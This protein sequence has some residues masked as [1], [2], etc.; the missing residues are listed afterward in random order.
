MSSLISRVA[1]L[2]ALKQKSLIKLIAVLSVVTFVGNIVPEWYSQ[3]PSMASEES[4]VTA[5]SPPSHPGTMF[6]MVDRLM[7]PTFDAGDHTGGQCA[8]NLATDAIPSQSAAG[9][10]T[11]YDA[12]YQAQTVSGSNALTI[13]F[14]NYFS[15]LATN[16]EYNVNYTLPNIYRESGGQLIIDGRMGSTGKIILQDSSSNHNS[17]NHFFKISDPSPKTGSLEPQFVTIRNIAFTS[18]L[19]LTSAAITTDNI[20]TTGFKEGVNFN[21]LHIQNNYFGTFDGV[22]L[23]PTKAIIQGVRVYYNHNTAPATQISDNNFY[24]VIGSSIE[25]GGNAE[26]KPANCP[27]YPDNQSEVDG[28]LLIESNVIGLNVDK[29]ITDESYFGQGG[30]SGTAISICQLSGVTITDNDIAN[31]LGIAM[32]TAIGI[33]QAE[34][35]IDNNR[36]G[37]VLDGTTYRSDDEW[38][39][40]GYGILIG[41]N[42]EDRQ[43]P[44]VITN[45]TINNIKAP[46]VPGVITANCPTP[47]FHSLTARGGSCG[48]SGIHLV[49]TSFN[50]IYQNIIGSALQ[51]N[52]GYGIE[53][54]GFHFGDAITAYYPSTYNKIFNNTIGYNAADG[55]YVDS[56]YNLATPRGYEDLECE[57]DF[58]TSDGETNNC[59]NTIVQ[60][61]LIRNGAYN[62]NDFCVSESAC[63][64]SP[65]GGIGI[66]LKTTTDDLE[67]KYGYIEDFYTGSG[68]YNDS[69]ITVNDDLDT[70]IGGNGAINTPV[71]YGTGS[72]M[73]GTASTARVIYGNLSDSTPGAYWVEV[74]AVNCP[75]ELGSTSPTITEDNA[76]T[77][78]D[79]DSISL[80]HQ[81]NNIT[82]GQGA[83][84]LCGAFV[85]KVG[86][87][88]GEWNCSPSAQF[89]INFNGA[90]LITATA[91]R[92]ADEGG[93]LPKET[94]TGLPAF[95]RTTQFT[96]GY[97]NYIF[98]TAPAECTNSTPDTFV[99]TTLS[100]AE[101]FV[102]I[103]SMNNS[104]EFS[105][106]V[107]VAPE[108]VDIVKMVRACSGSTGASCESNVFAPEITSSREQYVEYR[109]TVTNNTDSAVTPTI[110]DE[111]HPG[112]VT[113]LTGSC[114]TYNGLTSL[115]ADRPSTG[116]TPVT[117]TGN[118]DATFTPTIAA[119][120]SVAFFGM[121]RINADANGDSK[122]NIGR[123]ILPS[124][125][126][127]TSDDPE[128]YCT[129][130]ARVRITAPVTA[131][132]LKTIENP[133]ANG[134]TQTETITSSSSSQTI[135][136]RIKLD[137]SGLTK[138]NTNGLTIFDSFPRTI[139]DSIQM[140]YSQTSCTYTVLVNGVTRLGPNACLNREQ[141]NTTDDGIIIWNSNTGLPPASIINETTGDIE[142]VY[143]EFDTV[144]VIITYT[145]TVPANAITAS[146][147]VDVVNKATFSGSDVFPGRTGETTLTITPPQVSPTIQKSV[148][149]CTSNTVASCASATFNDTGVT[150]APGN[151]VEY[152]LAIT[153]S[154]N[155]TFAINDAAPTGITF[156]SD[157]GSCSL[158]ANLT[159]AVA[160]T[161]ARPSSTATPCTIT[162]A[163]GATPQT[164]AM[165]GQTLTANRFTYVYILATVSPSATTAITNT[166]TIIGSG[167][168]TENVCSNTA[169][170]TPSAVPGEVA[171]DKQASA[172][173]IN[174]GQTV[175]YTVTIDKP[176]TYAVNG[177]TL[178]DSFPTNS[179]GIT[180][181]CQSVTV[182]PT[183]SQT[184]SCPTGGL[185][186]SSGNIFGGI[187]IAQAVTRITVVYTATAPSSI[188]TSQ[189]LV[190]NVALTG[191]RSTD[192]GAISRTDSVPVLITTGTI[193]INKTAD[194]NVT[195]TN[196]ATEKIYKPGDTVN[197]T[198]SL[199]NTSGATVAGVSIRD[200]FHSLLGSIAVDTTGITNTITLGGLNLTGISVPTGTTPTTIT[201]HGTIADRSD[202]DLDIFDLDENSNPARDDDFYA[203][204][205]DS[206]VIDDSIRSTNNSHR[207]ADDILGAPDNKFVSLNK[208]DITIDL[209]SKVIVNG[210][211]DDFALK[212][213]NQNTDDTDQGT[214]EFTVEVSQ[215]NR[216]YKEIDPRDEDRASYDLSKARMSWVRYIRITDESSAT[217]AQAPGVDIDAICLL[218]IGV[219]LPNTATLTAG[220]QTAFDTEEI[221]VDI[222]KVFDKKPSIDNC[223][224]PELT[225][226]PVPPLAA[227]PTV[228]PPVQPTPPAPP[229][230]LPKTGPAPL[231]L[232]SIVS[233][234]A[235]IFTRKRQ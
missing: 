128:N 92:V 168:T 40:F 74:F 113:W 164:L 165:S 159:T 197:Y 191:T 158:Y 18:L 42:Y 183:G 109:I 178:H 148:R 186:G 232:L 33:S 58:G 68:T 131:T 34:A 72:D 138:A 29:E 213:I 162:P 106:N 43:E 225:V 123:L 202:F 203:S 9:T 8:V 23:D 95:T 142:D 120:T 19:K 114:A 17:L 214:E 233:S 37:N 107:Y 172:S 49:A 132:I 189:T 65:T 103:Y 184:I 181:A 104:S 163:S 136:Y 76:F 230:V 222:T 111:L 192:G 91:T 161:G 73:S 81:D 152:R 80:N 200:V 28:S 46:F 231:A 14:S 86:G 129:S 22:T 133:H 78:C 127:T 167:C 147:A 180:Y 71:L 44:T 206:E 151:T 2:F 234:F 64:E 169:L 54:V 35:T 224:E 219:Q 121:V 99:P 60:N 130:I 63:T 62:E 140:T 226:A 190:N 195:G 205:D 144:T 141:I 56:I 218:N 198:L 146:P 227:P 182:L 160:A 116:A 52:T 13:I 170:V 199:L 90:G 210:S 3:L 185:P 235:W 15:T 59:G 16:Y 61:N 145:G 51:I 154:A 50:F 201:Y 149:T 221:T 212:L 24:N 110:R 220:S 30:W 166:A 21:Q 36:I 187:T 179:V 12:I 194:N 32:D 41:G 211:G 4:E 105:Q 67:Q 193:S 139:R 97:L 150:T 207:R 26:A 27:Q 171:L 229:P 31:S 83:R 124:V 11:L 55:I 118:T 70:D 215:D 85:L 122:D 216:T 82:H 115:P 174:P 38:Q 112:Q 100:D 137:L 84:F 7:Q 208:G 209:G 126:C 223:T 204:E 135:D 88:A 134:T 87:D 47:S 57:T 196:H 6:I 89:G 93:E 156:G 69:D 125:G 45:N 228:A 143:T 48:G 157:T 155:A 77:N 25:L 176:N 1:H 5:A 153:S 39:I 175:T 177:A 96:C 53:I 10:C 102:A 117:C 188:T 101:I 173:S 94:E 20:T 98:T 75:A 217:K 108:T 66:D 119:N 79:T